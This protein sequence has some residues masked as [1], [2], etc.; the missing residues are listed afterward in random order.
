MMKHLSMFLVLIAALVLM[1]GKEA[2]GQIPDFNC[3]DDPSE[4]YLWTRVYKEITFAGCEWSV[5]ICVQCNAAGPSY[6]KL[7]QFYKK[8]DDCVTT[9]SDID[10]E[11]VKQFIENFVKAE[12]TTYGLFDQGCD[13]P[14]PCASEPPP[15][16]GVHYKWISPKCWQKYH[17]V[18][19]EVDEMIYYPC[20]SSNSE[21][22]EEFW[23]CY[24]ANKKI[25]TTQPCPPL[26]SMPNY[27]DCNTQADNEP[28]PP[29]GLE[30]GC[31]YFSLTCPESP[32][33]CAKEE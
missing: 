9:P 2:A 26:Y 21:C 11:V 22:I 4:E 13:Y 14:E 18:E 27:P 32:S 17:Y 3:A 23:M 33:N 8:D 16:S 24:D 6:A 20:R 19:G 31:F 15:Y 1:T 5:W 10:I 30:S 25:F 28:D 29:P 7:G 12:A